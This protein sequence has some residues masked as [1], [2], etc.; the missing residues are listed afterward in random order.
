[1]IINLNMKKETAAAATDDSVK[2]SSVEINAAGIRRR[3]AGATHNRRN[4]SDSYSIEI[5]QE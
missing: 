4:S 5:I 1:M 3:P 2:D